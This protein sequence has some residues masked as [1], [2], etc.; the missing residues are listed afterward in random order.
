VEAMFCEAARE[1]VRKFEGETQEAQWSPA[2]AA[3]AEGSNGGGH[4]RSS[5]AGAEGKKQ[6]AQRSGRRCMWGQLGMLESES[7]QLQRALQEVTTQVESLMTAYGQSQVASRVAPGAEARG[8]APGPPLRAVASRDGTRASPRRDSS[9]RA[10][11]AP[12]GRAFQGDAPAAPAVS[13]SSLG[14]GTADA[15]P[16][17][18]GIGA[19]TPA[20]AQDRSS[21]AL[22]MDPVLVSYRATPALDMSNVSTEGEGEAPLA[23][24][25]EEEGEGAS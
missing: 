20:E 7:A 11:A 22:K 23:V 4:L 21:E 18:P 17:E 8:G 25:D 19:R 3:A 15:E 1:V 2:A 14:E 10:V 9:D 5:K 12:A 13:A 6:M 16:G 24:G